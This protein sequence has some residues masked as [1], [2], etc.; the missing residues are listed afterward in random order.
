MVK[1]ILAKLLYYTKRIEGLLQMATLS[2]TEKM[3]SLK[4]IEERISLWQQEVRNLRRRIRDLISQ[5][6]KAKE[7]KTGWLVQV[8]LDEERCDL[9]EIAR[10]LL[11][12]MDR[13][14]DLLESKQGTA[15]KDFERNVIL[16]EQLRKCHDIAV[17]IIEQVQRGMTAIEI[18]NKLA[19]TFGGEYKW[20]AIVG[21]CLLVD[22]HDFFKN[23]DDLAVKQRMLDSLQKIKVDIEPDEG[24]VEG[25]D[26]PRRL[27]NIQ[28]VEAR[29]QK[30]QEELTLIPA[31]ARE[32]CCMIQSIKEAQAKLGQLFP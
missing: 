7:N 31:Y 23:P 8:A 6:A 1:Y 20:R 12:D 4:E 22:I 10:S 14:G 21:N 19:R 15:F 26:K 13:M 3:M 11:A 16:R 27:R 18:E 24:E 32:I 9:S 17:C 25:D 2:E 29:I 30:T 5:S 28:E